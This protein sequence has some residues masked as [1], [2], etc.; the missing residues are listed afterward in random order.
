M[1]TDHEFNLNTQ[2]L[3]WDT[4]NTALI[5]CNN[6]NCNYFRMV[7]SYLLSRAVVT[8]LSFLPQIYTN[9]NKKIEKV[10][11]FIMTC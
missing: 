3:I 8:E 11:I 2:Q 5:L 4:L 1:I 6:R 9:I 7:A 10:C